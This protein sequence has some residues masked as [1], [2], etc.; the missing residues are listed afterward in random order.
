MPDPMISYDDRS[1]VKGRRRFRGEK[2]SQDRERLRSERNGNKYN[3]CCTF[4][5][6]RSYQNGKAW[7]A[8]FFVIAVIIGKTT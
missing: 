4:H 7:Q 3:R 5:V 1:A 6:T 2:R 8:N